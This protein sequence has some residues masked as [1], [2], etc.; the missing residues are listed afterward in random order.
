MTWNIEGYSRSSLEIRQIVDSYTPSL[1]FISE[2]WLFLSDLKVAT[3]LLTPQYKMF[4]NSDDLYNPDLP[5]L[6]SRAHGGTLTLWKAE[7][8]PYITILPTQTSR[9]LPILLDYP[10]YQQTIHVNIYLPTS[11]RESDFI[12]SL[13]SLQATIDHA[14]ESY[15]S[16]LIYV[17][18]DANAC[19]SPRPNN[20][21][22]L[23][24]HQFI[25]DNAFL[26]LCFNS[27][28]TYHHFLGSG[29]SDSSIDVALSSTASSD[30]TP[31]ASSEILLAVLCSKVKTRTFNSHH[32][33]I[34]TRILLR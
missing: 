19:S 2:P 8:D 30:G 17:K 33:A 1:L 16:A 7:L 23:V 29:V 20:K 26:P 28:K 32:D 4:L 15:P 12:E 34:I 11:G 3:Q 9:I 6:K 21:R 24:F 31:S 25:Q 22:D 14:N 13:A 10:G 5:L 27:H 18:G